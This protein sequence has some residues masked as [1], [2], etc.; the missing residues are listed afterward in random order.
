MSKIGTDNIIAAGNGLIE[1]ADKVG[2][3]LHNDNKVDVFE[4]FGISMT[5]IGVGP[6]I[7]RSGHELLD[8]DA[9]ENVDVQ[10]AFKAKLE[11]LKLDEANDSIEEWA[12]Q[13]LSSLIATA[14]VVGKIAD[15]V[16]KA[17]SS[18]SEKA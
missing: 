9:Q 4:G 14:Q 15:A 16:S 6:N 7:V 17:K 10:K 18:S 5:V 3:A 13:L 1:A 11:A 8:V 2:D 12:E